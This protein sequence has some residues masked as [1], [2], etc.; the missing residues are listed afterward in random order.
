MRGIFYFNLT[1]AA[2]V[3]KSYLEELPDVNRLKPTMWAEHAQNPQICGV[4][5]GVRK[6]VRPL[7]IFIKLV[8]LRASSRNTQ[9][10]FA[11]SETKAF[12]ASLKYSLSKYDQKKEPC[13]SCTVTFDVLQPSLDGP[14]SF[15]FP[16]GNCAEYDI[17]RS[18]NLNSILD[19]I[20]E[21]WNTFRN[22][23]QRRF[24]AFIKYVSSCE[25]VNERDQQEYM[26]IQ[27]GNSKILKYHA[28]GKHGVHYELK[29][30]DWKTPNE[31]NNKK[32]RRAP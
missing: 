15:K 22:A 24:K 11:L 19:A 13:E 20:S 14:P 10:S 30:V 29:V 6:F 32:R 7:F 1:T 17:I 5:I 12:K 26:D 3:G 8:Q 27:I 21:D 16:F 28:V 25:A 23:C 9:T 18:G 2:S 4:S 31:T